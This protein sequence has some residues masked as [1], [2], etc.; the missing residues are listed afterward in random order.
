V[1]ES[2][3]KIDRLSVVRQLAVGGIALAIAF[4]GS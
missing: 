2:R 4:G 1:H 3:I